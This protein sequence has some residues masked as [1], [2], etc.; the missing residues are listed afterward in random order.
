MSGLV[1]RAFLISAVVGALVVSASPAAA[2]RPGTFEFSACWDG[3]G[4]VASLSWSGFRVS[5]YSFG[6]GQDNGDGLGFFEPI[7][8]A[9]SGSFSNDWLDSVDN[10]VDLVAGG[11]YGH[12]QRRAIRSG[13]VH[14][15]LGGWSALD[16][17]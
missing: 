12:S 1:R 7:T 15:P 14:R 13:E 16:P 11:V 17:C 3:D 5:Q 10:T 9:T 8:P 2:A 6:F 4:V